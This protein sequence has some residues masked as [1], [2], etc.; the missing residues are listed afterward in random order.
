MSATERDSLAVRYRGLAIKAAARV[1][2]RCPRADRDD[3]FAEAW[4]GV[5]LAARTYDPDRGAF[6]PHAATAADQTVRR[7]V[8]AFVLRAGL[9]GSGKAI[10]EGRLAPPVRR[11]LADDRAI[12]EP[13]P[14]PEL[15]PGL[16]ER[17]AESLDGRERE[18][19]LRHFRDGLTH[20]A[21]ADE[22]GTSRQNVQNA[23]RRG[24]ERL[25]ERFP[26]WADNL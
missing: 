3:L 14:P 24:L 4:L 22:I 2:R 21:V 10:R 8:R 7:F 23:C 16:W 19:V 25:R 15:P 9:Y 5:L 11:E 26:G 17:V 18:C 12:D 13:D 6:G 1:R 20:A